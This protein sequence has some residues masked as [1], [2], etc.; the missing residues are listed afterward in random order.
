MC[1]LLN[2][3]DGIYAAPMQTPQIKA[4]CPSEGCIQGGQTVI[5]IGENF[6]EGLQVSQKYCILNQVFL[7]KLDVIMHY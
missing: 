2:V 1:N 3:S 7:T 6:C 5:I 4:V